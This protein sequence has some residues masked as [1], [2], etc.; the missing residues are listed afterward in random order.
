[1][2]PGCSVSAEVVMSLGFLGCAAS[3]WGVLA[4]SGS[5]SCCGCLEAASRPFP[6]PGALLE[7]AGGSSSLWA[8]SKWP[9]CLRLK[10]CMKWA[11]SKVGQKFAYC[12]LQSGISHI[13]CALYLTDGIERISEGADHV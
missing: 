8:I 1:M 3:L 13:D 12:L 9:S 5:F 7:A 4:A 10:L 2:P 6:C 11:Q